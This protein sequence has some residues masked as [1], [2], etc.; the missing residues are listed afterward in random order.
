MQPGIG[1]GRGRHHAA[2]RNPYNTTT[3][4]VIGITGTIGSG[5]STVGRILAELGCPV[6]DADVEAHRSYGKGTRAYRQIVA[7]FG[8]GILDAAGKIDRRA[9]GP[10][11]FA[12][13]AARE[14][15]NA[16]VH[17]AARRRVASRLRRL[18]RQGHRFAA[19]E[20]TLLIEAGWTDMV[21]VLWV[22]AAPVD[23][24]IARLG[25]DRG[26]DEAE[27]RSRL[28]TQLPAQQMMELADDIIY[29]DGD[30]A[31]LRARVEVLWHGLLAA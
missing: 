1:T 25:R 21:D 28:S 12:D 8:P 31:A 26:Q 3:M 29:N 5:K 18:G 15:L 2:V 19:V 22:V 17:P 7:D 9:L 13:T 10:I 11:V 24:V 20:A 16:I 30:T 4:T 23:S 6:V 14:R 27:I